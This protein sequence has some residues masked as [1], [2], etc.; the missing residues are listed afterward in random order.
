M[1]LPSSLLLLVSSVFGQQT[2]QLSFN[3]ILDA[4]VN[5]SAPPTV[6]IIPSSVG[7]LNISVSLCS[8]QLPPPQF[9]LTND[10][11]GGVPKLGDNGKSIFNITLEE[12]LGIWGGFVNNGGLL[13]VYAGDTS[14][15]V[16][17]PPWEFQV[18]VSNSSGPLV[19]RSTYSL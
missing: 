16:I 18:G 7:A 12:G 3:Q 9:I 17:Y 19:T 6:F 2:I 4:T 10:T 13:A 11:S 8:S 1:L 5:A 15:G 14:L